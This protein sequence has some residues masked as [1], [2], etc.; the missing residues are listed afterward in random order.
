[1]LRMAMHTPA[2]IEK[3]PKNTANRTAGRHSQQD[4]NGC[5]KQTPKYPRKHNPHALHLKQ[6]QH[7]KKR[8]QTCAQNRGTHRTCNK[9]PAGTFTHLRRTAQLN[10]QSNPSETTLGVPTPLLKKAHRCIHPM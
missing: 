9:H 2:S 7:N 5:T 4:R 10:S 6:K 8:Q 3:T 1:M